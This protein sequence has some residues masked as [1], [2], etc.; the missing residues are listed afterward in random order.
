MNESSDV[1]KVPSA[2]QVELESRVLSLKS[3]Q[4]PDVLKTTLPFSS[5]PGFEEVTFNLSDARLSSSGIVVPGN[6]YGIRLALSG[7]AAS[8]VLRLNFENGQADVYPGTDITGE[9][10]NV[11]V[12]IPT[13]PVVGDTLGSARL[14]FSRRPDFEFEEESSV[15]SNFLT[16]AVGPSGGVTQSYNAAVT[17]IGNAPQDPADGVSLTGVTALRARVT[18]SNGGIL[19]GRIRWWVQVGGNWYISTVS[20]DLN[21]E[22]TGQT[23]CC[24]SDFFAPAGG[25]RA[26]CDLVLGTNTGGSGAFTVEIDSRRS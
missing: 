2:F 12:T 11:V 9:F 7:T 25:L 14:I 21:V 15:P 24:T 16:R 20:E 17:S 18:S 1:K 22:V 13:A 19:S 10:R 23:R 4:A 5:L 26:S 8:A 6:F 3:K